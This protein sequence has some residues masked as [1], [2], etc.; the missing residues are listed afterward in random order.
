MFKQDSG[1]IHSSGKLC[2][3]HGHKVIGKA[4][5]AKALPL[6]LDLERVA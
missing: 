1:M 3:F 5:A 4:Y 6:C 2:A